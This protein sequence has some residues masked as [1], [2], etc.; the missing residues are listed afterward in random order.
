[1]RAAPA[2]LLVL[3]LSPPAHADLWGCEVLLCMANP[4]GPIAAPACDP[5]MKRLWRHLG[6]RGAKWP[7]CPQANNL[8][9]NTA[10]AMRPA[11]THECPE[12]LVV[13]P[14]PD[15]QHQASCNASKVIEVR[16]S[17]QLTNRTWVGIQV[18]GQSEP[19]FFSQ[20]MA[21]GRADAGSR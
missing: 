18:P 11:L 12:H 15:S 14:D 10:I 8:S 7:S 3:L 13:P 9:T 17:G 6:K 4:A 16:V 1:M 21:A 19:M 5:P 2:F 20:T